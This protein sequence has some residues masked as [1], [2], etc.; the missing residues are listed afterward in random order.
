MKEEDPNLHSALPGVCVD[1]GQGE[2]SQVEKIGVEIRWNDAAEL[3][4]DTKLRF[5]DSPITG[6]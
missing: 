3:L 1:Q 4:G 2:T 5:S 6:A